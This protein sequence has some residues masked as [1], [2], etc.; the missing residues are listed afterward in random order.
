MGYWWM[1]NVSRQDKPCNTTDWLWLAVI[2][3]FLWEGS[4]WAETSVRSGIQSTCGTYKRPRNLPIKIVQTGE[5]GSK[6]GNR[7]SRE[8]GP[9]VSGNTGQTATQ[10]VT[11]KSFLFGPKRQSNVWT[12]WSAQRHDTDRLIA[13]LTQYLWD[14]KAQAPPLTVNTFSLI[15]WRLMKDE[16]RNSPAPKRSPDLCSRV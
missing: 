6:Q 13:I 1:W 16:G 8:A 7:S 5:M 11:Q 14:E 10:R 15:R 9:C 12:G 3:W 2:S 4:I